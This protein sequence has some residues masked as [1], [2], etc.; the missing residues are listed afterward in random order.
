M[1]GT[2][3]SWRSPGDVAPPTLQPR[4]AAQ[5]VPS[6]A[7]H[8]REHASREIA[9]AFPD[10]WAH[11]FPETQQRFVTE[12]LAAD[13]LGQ[14]AARKVVEAWYRTLWLRQDPAFEAHMAEDLS[15]ET[16]ITTERELKRR[17]RL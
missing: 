4:K 14:D 17:L 11:L 7:D 9:K 10:L 2:T 1:S 3:A 6:L 12:L 8:L 15:G 13:G 16:P 5:K